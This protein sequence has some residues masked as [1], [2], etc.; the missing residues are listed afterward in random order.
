MDII[1]SFE[2]RWAQFKYYPS[3]WEFQ[4]NASQSY[5]ICSK[6]LQFQF[7]LSYLESAQKMDW[8][9]YKKAYY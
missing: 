8:N 4:M 7:L 5:K 3:P 2:T 6:I 1:I 9:R